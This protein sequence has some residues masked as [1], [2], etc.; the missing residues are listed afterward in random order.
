MD[1]LVRFVCSRKERELLTAALVVR[2]CMVVYSAI[3][4]R[5]FAVHRSV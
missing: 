2:L 4:D 3:H 1:R 5:L